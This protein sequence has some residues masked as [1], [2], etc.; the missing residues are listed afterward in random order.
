MI[1]HLK[2]AEE[3]ISHTEQSQKSRPWH[4]LYNRV[5][6]C[7]FVCAAVTPRHLNKNSKSLA[8]WLI[9]GH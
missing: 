8:K 1:R 3:D 2:L 7:E 6:V 4:M 5:V 9:V